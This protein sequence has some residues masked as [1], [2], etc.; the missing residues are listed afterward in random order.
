[1]DENERL[2]LNFELQED[3]FL[4][5]QNM[6]KDSKYDLCNIAIQ[7]IIVFKPEKLFNRTEESILG[8]GKRNMQ[9]AEEIPTSNSFSNG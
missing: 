4:Y 8:K 5:V 6:V 1:M 7:N 2:Y 3:G 9:D